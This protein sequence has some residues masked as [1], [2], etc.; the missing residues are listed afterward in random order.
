[1]V[2]KLSLSLLRPRRGIQCV[3]TLRLP[4][5]LP[6]QAATAGVERRKA[7]HEG[8]RCR[9]MSLLKLSVRLVKVRGSSISPGSTAGG[10]HS[11]GRQACVC[12]AQPCR[13][14]MGGYRDISSCSQSWGK[15]GLH[16]ERHRTRSVC[17]H[18]L[19]DAV[20]VLVKGPCALESSI[21]T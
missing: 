19:V 14:S 4:P 15:W 12:Q 7:R 16:K 9:S 8:G 2:K 10:S 3:A 5:S 17:R 11:G 1:M 21:L 6:V 13:P 18:R 20:R